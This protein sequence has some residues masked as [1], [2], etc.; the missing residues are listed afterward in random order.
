MKT[1]NWFYKRIG[2][3]IYRRKNTC[4]CKSCLDT[5]ENGVLIIDKEHAEY[6]HMVDCELYRYYDKK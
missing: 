1:I 6:L 2:K 5:M 4:P 3:R